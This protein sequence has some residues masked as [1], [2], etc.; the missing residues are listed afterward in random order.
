MRG[1]EG[2]LAVKKKS[3]LKEDRDTTIFNI[4]ILSAKEFR[5]EECDTNNTITKI[6]LR[7]ES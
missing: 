3:C 5:V 6:F 1:R 4:F 2:I 7:D